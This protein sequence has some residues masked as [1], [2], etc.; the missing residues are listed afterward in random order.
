MLLRINASHSE[1]PKA[2]CCRGGAEFSSQYVANQLPLASNPLG[3]T[4]ALGGGIGG[5]IDRGG[6]T[7]ALLGARMLVSQ[8]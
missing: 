2:Q 4:T 1:L 3:I 5:V 6:A 7:H 8:V